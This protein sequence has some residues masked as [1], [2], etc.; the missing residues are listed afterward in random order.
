MN[1]KI[2][3][4][5]LLLTAVAK[6]SAQ[7]MLDTDG[8]NNPSNV[9]LVS[10]REYC[11]TLDTMETR[12]VYVKYD[13][14]IGQSWPTRIGNMEVRYV[15]DFEYKK[16]IDDHNGRVTIV[17]IS[18]LQLMKGDFYVGI[19]PFAASYRNK[20]VYLSNGGGW[21]VYFEYDPVHKGL[22]LVGKKYQGL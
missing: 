17:G 8:L 11:S 12:V 9:Y 4:S 16:A 14:F 3:I 22:F 5:I 15:R 19:I 20:S 1:F 2:L 13:N 10:L 6:C 7:S 21:K 18:P